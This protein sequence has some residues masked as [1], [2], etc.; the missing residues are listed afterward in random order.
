MTIQITPDE[1]RN[2][3]VDAEDETIEQ[4]ISDAIDQAAAIAPT[5]PTLTGQPAASA[6]AVIRGAVARYIETGQGDG[7]SQIQQTAGPFSQSASYQSRTTI[8]LPSEERKLAALESRGKHA[9]FGIDLAPRTTAPKTIAEA[10]NESQ[11]QDADR[12]CEI[13]AEIFRRT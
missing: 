1:I 8:F 10:L 3:G 2:Y 9:V 6:A 12:I 4:I 7:A 5:V 11:T 13:G